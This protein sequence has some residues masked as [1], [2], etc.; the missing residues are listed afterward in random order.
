MSGVYQ[1]WATASASDGMDI[2]RG[3]SEINIEWTATRSNATQ[4]VRI[5]TEAIAAESDPYRVDEPRPM[6]DAAPARTWAGEVNARIAQDEV[7]ASQRREAYFRAQ[8]AEERLAREEDA[9][10]D[11]VAERIEHGKTIA[12]RPVHF[13]WLDGPA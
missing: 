2:T 13:S 6:F 11:E 8:Q 7:L 10:Y 5:D 12:E 9:E 3:E 1:Y 4:Y